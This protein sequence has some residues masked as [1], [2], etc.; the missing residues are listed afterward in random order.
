MKKQYYKIYVFNFL[1][2]HIEDGRRT[3]HTPDITMVLYK[4]AGI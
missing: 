3:V 2:F 1:F 4:I